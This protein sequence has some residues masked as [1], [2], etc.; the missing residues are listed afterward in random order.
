M[1]DLNDLALFALVVEHG[2]Y[3]AVERSLGIPKSRLSRRVAALEDS[4]GVRLLQRSTRRFA[5]TEVGQQ[6]YRHA[7]VMREEAEAARQAVDLLSREPRGLLRVSCPVALAQQQLAVLLPQFLRQHP[8]VRLQLQVS[9]RR[10]DL[11]DEGIDIALRVRT[12]IDDDPGLIVKRF[13]T[14]RELLVASPNYLGVHGAPQHPGELTRHVLLS[15]FDEP[16]VQRWE[17]IDEAGSSTRIEHEPRVA[18]KD[19]PLLRRLAEDGF[20]IALLP[21]T[22]CADLLSNGRLQRVLPGWDMPLGVCHAVFASRRGMLP[23]LRAFI[24]HLDANLPCLLSAS[25]AGA[26]HPEALAAAGKPAKLSPR[27][28]G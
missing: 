14:I 21:E 9:N 19:F 7:R 23:A 27:P 22:V 28:A 20:G 24:D 8:K 4:F 2:G 15:M 5:V 12:R 6:V 11:I 17:L 10:V 18:A 16:G 25:K 1:D 3:A 13:G 26:V